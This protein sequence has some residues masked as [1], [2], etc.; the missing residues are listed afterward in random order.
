MKW[1]RLHSEFA[2]DVKVQSMSEAMQRR[3]VMLFCIQ[4][5]PGIETFHE[6]QRETLLACALRISL[7][8]L[9]ATKEIFLSLG[10]INQDF[11]LRNWT[12]RQYLSDTSTQRV[13]KF[14]A[15]KASGVTF[16][17]RSRNAPRLQKQIQKHT[18]APDFF[19]QA[20]ADL[21]G[22]DTATIARLWQSARHASPDISAAEILTLITPHFVS[23]KKREG[24]GVA[25]A[26]GV[27]VASIGDWCSPANLAALRAQTAA[28]NEPRGP[29]TLLNCSTPDGEI[30]DLSDYLADKS[31]SSNTES[32]L[33]LQTRLDHLLAERAAETPPPRKKPESAGNLELVPKREGVR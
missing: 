28:A 29:V 33:I 19:A 32:R 5:D 26:I 13:R 1:C 18:A 14:R 30:K 4:S 7:A 31:I 8:D 12:E 17:E 16:P 24:R 9:T 21:T 15:R 23:L 3:L 20:A 10:F 25:T 22:A 6:T 27:T 2:H 11:T